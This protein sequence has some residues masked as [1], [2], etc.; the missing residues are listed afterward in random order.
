MIRLLCSALAL[1]TLLCTCGPAPQQT[2]G[3]GTTNHLAGEKSPYLLQHA[4]NPVDWYPWGEAA[5]TRAKNEDK[6]MVISVGYAACH[7]CHVME[8]ESFEDSL[9]ASVM[10]EHFVSVKVDREER[11]D[12]DDVYMTACQLTNQRGC[13]WPLNVIALPDGRPVWAGTYLPKK[14]WLTVLER[15]TA[16]RLSEPGK[17]EEYAAGLTDELVRQNSFQPPAAGPAELR[18][19]ETAAAAA[20]ILLNEDRER[21]GRAGSPKFPRPAVYEFLL[22]QHFYTG[23]EAALRA[24]TTLLDNMAAG[25]IYDQL[26]GGFSRYSTDENWLVPHFEKMLYDNGQLLSLYAHAYR[27]TGREDYARVVRETIGFLDRSLSDANGLFYSS[28]DADT[29]G[30]EGLTY[31]WSSREIDELLTDARQRRAF[32]AYYGVSAAGNWEGHNILNVSGEAARIAEQEKYADEAALATDLAAARATLLAARARRP[33]PGLD[34]KALTAWNGLAISGYAAAY[35][36]LGEEA[37]RERAVRAAGFL[38]DHL[39]AADGRLDRNYKDGSAG[40]NGFLDDYALFAQA[41]VDVY[42][43]TFDEA[44]LGTARRLVD[45]AGEHFF[46]EAAGLYRYTSRLDPALVS[47]NVPVI[48]K[49]IPAGNSAMA[50]VL[51]QLGTLTAADTLRERAGAMLAAVQP[52]LGEQGES[53]GNWLRLYQEMLQPTYEVAIMGA[54]AGAVRR[55]LSKVYLPNVLLLG[56][57]QEGELELLQYKLI[58]GQTTIYV[59]LDK[60]CQLPVTEPAAALSQLLEDG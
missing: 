20:R 31:V 24:V 57:E 7:W 10:N 14:R 5:L 28:L 38:R 53:M 47:A 30:E 6:L 40:I 59:C 19:E 48:D 56:G 49:A 4:R 2:A 58:P 46:D 16:L 9:V 41:C 60:V 1:V 18:A 37:Y 51:Y 33:Q 13:G 12:V 17:M 23:D 39:L 36:A 22:A 27:A 29:E 50:R 26:G 44:W 15:F 25:G 42:Q 35:L 21:G 52:R 8:H 43:I 3:G 32:R 54:D 11:P 55:T 34:D 45:Y